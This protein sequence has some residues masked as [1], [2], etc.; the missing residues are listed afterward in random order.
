LQNMVC[1]VLNNFHS[2]HSLLLCNMGL[3]HFLS[4]FVDFLDQIDSLQCPF[5]FILFSFSMF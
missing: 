4:R 2:Q 1:N 3:V 5:L